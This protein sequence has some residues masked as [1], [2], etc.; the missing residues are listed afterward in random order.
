MT[1]RF[2]TFLS[3]AASLTGMFTRARPMPA[4]AELDQLVDAHTAAVESGDDDPARQ[5]A[6]QQALLIRFQRSGS[7]DD[8]TRFRQL[9]RATFEALS[10]DH[11]LY[12]AALTHVLVAERIAFLAG[13]QNA[14]LDEAVAAGEAFLAALPERDRP[15]ELANAVADAHMTAW[16]AWSRLANLHRGV[17]LR[18][19]VYQGHGRRSPERAQA[20]IDLASAHRALFDASDEAAALHKAVQYAAEAC[21]LTSLRMPPPPEI[22]AT[23]ALIYITGPDAG[24][25]G[26]GSWPGMPSG[27]SGEPCR[28]SLP[29]APTTST[30]STMSPAC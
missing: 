14:R 16:Q 19:F 6:L 27:R 25:A 20:T 22:L 1:R 29:R 28:R 7:S 2:S 4:G 30:C 12:P 11:D 15:L 13:D 23:A 18:H 24:K 3:D 9:A 10:G 17:E 8:L 21:M 5:V 26:G